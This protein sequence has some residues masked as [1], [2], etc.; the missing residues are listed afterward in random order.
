MK[1]RRHI[2]SIGLLLV[3]AL[4]GISAHA[5]APKSAP[6]AK[7][8]E[9]A[10]WLA[11]CKAWNGKVMTIQ[12]ANLVVEYPD[13]ADKALAK[14]HADFLQKAYEK[15]RQLFAFGAEDPFHGKKI[16]FHVLP[17]WSLGE[18][19]GG[20]DIRLG[21]GTMASG[22]AYPPDRIYF[23]EMAHAF[24]R[25]QSDHGRYY[26]YQFIGGMNEAVAMLFECYI[27]TQLASIAE[28]PNLKQ[29]CEDHLAGNMARLVK[30]P[31]ATLASYESHKVN[32]YALDWGRHPHQKPGEPFKSGEWYFLQMLF[33][34]TH[35]YGWGVWSKLF[36]ETAKSGQGPVAKELFW[37]QTHAHQEDPKFKQAV[38]EFVEALGKACGH[39]LRPMFRKWNFG[40]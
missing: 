37:N 6:P 4:F 12:T 22:L 10:D 1:W 20:T 25:A 31:E 9:Q 39:D 7:K 33:R 18:T 2:S 29:A 32:P 17:A 15:Y 3:I 16:Q 14:R 5:G 13:F 11:K 36:A 30:S 24:E 23:H 38:A 40:F 28:S 8:V 26:L 21:I 35:D 19:A 34:V 27:S